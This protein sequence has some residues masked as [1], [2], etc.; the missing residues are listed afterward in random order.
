MVNAFGKLLQISV[1]GDA[2]RPEFRYALSKI[3]DGA[4]VC[5]VSSTEEFFRLKPPSLAARFAGKEAV[6]KALDSDVLYFKEIEILTDSKGRP[7]V[8]L[9]GKTKEYADSMGIKDIDLSLSHTREYAV[10]CAVCQ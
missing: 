5:C 10:A 3:S 2:N 1:V 7:V 9:Y 8:N 4:F 6:F